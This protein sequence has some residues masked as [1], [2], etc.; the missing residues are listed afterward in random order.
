MK[1]IITKA[2]NDQIKEEIS[3]AYIY[4][5]MSTWAKLHKLLG[6]SNWFEIQTK[7]K[8]DHAMGFYKYLL[9][10]DQPIELLAIPQP[11]NNFEKPEN[12]FEETLKHEK[13][14]TDK[15]YDLLKLAQTQEDAEF[16]NFLKWYLDEQVEE[17]DNVVKY[18]D[19]LK[20]IG[21]DLKELQNIDL[22]LGQRVYKQ[23]NPEN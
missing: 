20:A 4:F 2:I 19:Q 17:E 15:I 5:S 14:M 3:S 18:A 21:N 13:Y 11:P 6:F 10:N 23:A 16:E 8:I 12:L 7:E 9:K 1:L 22:L